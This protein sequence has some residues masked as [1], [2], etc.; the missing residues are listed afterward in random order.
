MYHSITDHSFK[1]GYPPISVF[2][3]LLIVTYWLL[4]I[5]IIYIDIKEGNGIPFK[6]NCDTVICDSMTQLANLNY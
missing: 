4:N 2:P 1:K 5:Y 3:S 6:N